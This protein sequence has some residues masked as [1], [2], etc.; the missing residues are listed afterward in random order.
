MR[1]RDVAHAHLSGGSA[2]GWDTL[3]SVESEGPSPRLQFSLAPERQQQHEALLEQ[4]EDLAQAQPDQAQAALARFLLH[5]DV[6]PEL[7]RRAARL[8]CDVGNLGMMHRLLLQLEHRGALLPED[9]ADIVALSAI[10]GDRESFKAHRSGY[11]VPPTLLSLSANVL[12]HTGLGQLHRWLKQR[13]APDAPLQEADQSG[14]GAAPA[15]D[16]PAIRAQRTSLSTDMT[17]AS[18]R[19]D[20]ASASHL[21]LTL[22]H[23]TAG[24]LL[25]T[26]ECALRPNM[27]YRKGAPT[28]SLSDGALEGFLSVEPPIDVAYRGSTLTLEHNAGAAAIYANAAHLRGYALPAS[29]VSH[30]LSLAQGEAQTWI[31]FSHNSWVLIAVPDGYQVARVEVSPGET[32]TLGTLELLAW[33][34]TLFPDPEKPERSEDAHLL[35]LRGEATV[36]LALTR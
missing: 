31:R 34:G 29:P 16:T 23:A 11:T 20:A 35:T 17:A 22:E 1:K 26:Q 10:L 19:S 30:T 33:Q 6:A 4:V 3:L 14:A 15:P 28:L 21:A 27:L 18:Q 32:L 24:A 9:A 5:A 8:A 13:V 25:L 2:T 12:D 36:Y 7:V